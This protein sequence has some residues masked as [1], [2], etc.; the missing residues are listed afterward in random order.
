MMRK[1]SE[2]ADV[3]VD[4]GKKCTWGEIADD[5]CGNLHKCGWRGVQH[6]YY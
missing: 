2:E 1:K 5:R 6:P 4:M 3:A